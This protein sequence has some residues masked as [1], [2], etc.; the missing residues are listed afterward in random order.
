MLSH[1]LTPTIVTTLLSFLLSLVLLACG[2]GGSGSGTPPGNGDPT[3]PD[4]IPGST[5]VPVGKMI[6]ATSGGSLAAGD[7]A[8]LTIPPGAL[9][10]DTYITING[11]GKDVNGYQTSYIFGPDGL[12]FNTPVTLTMPF[13]LE[14]N[15]GSGEY[16][17]QVLMYSDANPEVDMGTEMS[18]WVSLDITEHDVDNRTVSVELDHFSDVFNLI[19]RI[20]DLANIVVDVPWKYLEPGDILCVLTTTFEDVVPG[21]KIPNWYPGHVGLYLDWP[22]NIPIQNPSLVVPSSVEAIPTFVTLSTEAQVRTPDFSHLFMGAR[23]PPS[24][25]TSPITA[26]QRRTI[27]SYALAQVGELYNGLGT[28]LP[29]GWNCVEL[30]EESLDEVDHG[31]FNQWQEITA[32]PRGM[33]EKTEPVTSIDVKLGETISIPVYG[34]VAA[35]PGLWENPDDPF[36]LLRDQERSLL[37]GGYLT[38]KAAT[39]PFDSE[40]YTITAKEIVSGESQNL[41][42]G[43]TFPISGTLGYHSF[44]WTPSFEDVLDNTSREV[45]FKMIANPRIAHM[46][47]D[48]FVQWE[49]ALVNPVTVTQRL[50][51]NVQCLAFSFEVEAV[52]GRGVVGY[53]Q[54]NY[55]PGMPTNAIIEEA[56]LIDMA[57][58]ETPGPVPF[59]NHTWSITYEGWNAQFPTTYGLTIH[60]SDNGDVHLPLET[61]PQSWAYFVTYYVPEDEE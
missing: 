54:S 20:E 27:L 30:V 23:R 21:I 34:V 26:K 1:R 57:T 14:D 50:M 5:V 48:I 10:E 42:E 28:I 39:D 52:Q 17:V 59:P 55:E 37:Y 13:K 24:F 4:P 33:W 36:Q 60:M 11:P 25:R 8:L 32:T 49:D 18:R 41:W 45:E 53:W 40:L 3:P 31:V 38:K 2:G 12:A 51:L 44:E 9:K 56:V 7:G 47:S 16:A 46:W 35:W 58:G 29:F 61:E 22:E 6:G 43:A 15:S 19:D